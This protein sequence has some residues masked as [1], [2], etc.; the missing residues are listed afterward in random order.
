MEDD[1]ND[2]ERMHLVSLSTFLRPLFSCFDFAQQSLAALDSLFNVIPSS[3][4]EEFLLTTISEALG[5]V[6][7]YDES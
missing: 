5:A 1:F 4:A 3:N 2:R 6:E 7:F